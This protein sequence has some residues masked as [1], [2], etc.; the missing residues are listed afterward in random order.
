MKVQVLYVTWFKEQ[1]N[2]S[3]SDMISLGIQAKVLDES[4]QM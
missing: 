4:W 1:H 2:S 3:N